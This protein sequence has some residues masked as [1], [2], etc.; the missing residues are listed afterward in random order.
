MLNRRDFLKH[1]RN[2]AVAAFGTEVLTPEIA[3]GFMKLSASDRPLVAFIQGQSCTACTISL[4]YGN[5]SDFIDFI[6]N[7]IR[8]QVHPNLSFSQGESYL[9]IL[10]GVSSAGGHVLVVE[11]S[12]PSRMKKA[13]ML[14]EHT[15]YDELKKHMENAFA[16]IASG[17]CSCFG[18]IPASGDNETGAISVEAYM[19]QNGIN[20]PLIKLPGCPVHPDRFMGTVAY[21]IAT[22]KLPPMRDGIPTQYYGEL[23]HNECS[24]FQYFSQDIYL[25]NF[26]KDKKSCLLKR[27]CRGTI[28]RADCP[29]RRWNGGVSMCVESNTP[30]IG[31]VHKD[32]PFNSDIYIEAK[33]VEDI[34]WG[35]F[36]KLSESKGSSK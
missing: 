25:E 26:D 7:L 22:G 3:E 4:T 32:W 19:K 35:E 16:V 15:L 13:C 28:T 5:E 20:K 17:T 27:G 1:C 24:R 2:I 29:A 30:C 34:P 31:C 8:L 11:G 10:N 33:N 14:G 12:I 21:I 6:T 9:N 18:G 36:K 23:I